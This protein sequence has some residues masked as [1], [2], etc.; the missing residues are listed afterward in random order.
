[1]RSEAFKIDDMPATDDCKSDEEI[2][3]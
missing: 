2:K 3:D 1:M